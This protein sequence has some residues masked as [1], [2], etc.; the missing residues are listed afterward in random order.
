MNIEKMEKKKDVKGLIKLLKSKEIMVKRQATKALANIADEKALESLI[1]SLKDKDNEVKQNAALALGKIGNRRAGEPL[2]QALNDKSWYV[3]EKVIEALGNLREEMAVEHLIKALGYALHEFG[4]DPYSITRRNAAE[5]LGKIGD[6]KAV[7]PLIQALKDDSLEVRKQA[8]KALVMIGK[9]AIE[10]LCLGLKDEVSIIRLAVAEVLDQ[11]EWKPI[12]DTER[13]H[14]LI[15]KK[16]W[17]DIIEL[18]ERAIEAL[19]QTPLRDED[20]EIQQ[21]AVETLIKIGEPVVNPV[22]QA[23]KEDNWIVRLNA[24]KV[25]GRIRDAR[26]VPFLISAYEPLGPLAMVDLDGQNEISEALMSIGEPSI[27]PLIQFLESCEIYEHNSIREGILQALEKIADPRTVG[28][29]ITSLKREMNVPQ[30][31]AKEALIKIGKPSVEPLIQVLHEHSSMSVRDTDIRKSV[32]EALGRIGDKR[33]VKPLFQFLKDEDKSIRYAVDEALKKI[34]DAGVVEPFIQILK[35]EDRDIR[36]SAARRLVM[37]GDIQ[38]I[39]PIINALN[40]DLIDSRGFI[41]EWLGEE[42]DIR[43][44]SLLLRVLKEEDEFNR[45]SAAEALGNLGDARAMDALIQA[46]EDEDSYVQEAAKRALD[47]IKA[48]FS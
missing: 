44:L 42:G 6:V 18:R 17:D 47:K 37:I 1:L 27:E 32:V 36:N 48:K 20:E 34:G 19:I 21:K 29:L 31:I 28:I 46:S 45:S 23:L 5:A 38:A 12:N 15:A 4:S 30:K 24:A 22:I 11:L 7:T 25:L 8:K 13:A 41:L 39:E 16:K 9:P 3:L 2:I 14:Y 10:P 40:D 43:S 26:A 33:A 35:N